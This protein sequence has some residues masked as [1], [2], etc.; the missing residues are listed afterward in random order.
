[1]HAG[2]AQDTEKSAQDT[3]KTPLGIKLVSFLSH[4]NQRHLHFSTNI[5]AKTI[6]FIL[7]FQLFS[8]TCSDVI[9]NHF[10]TSKSPKLPHRYTV[11]YCIQSYLQQDL[12]RPGR[13]SAVFLSLSPYILV[14]FI[15]FFI[16]F[17]VL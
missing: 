11:W 7:I 16:F 1:M 13:V 8:K 5:R 6:G 14:F 15:L 9:C 17:I 3:K 2:S 4:N 10:C 12:R